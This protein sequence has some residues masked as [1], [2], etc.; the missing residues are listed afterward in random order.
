MSY[1]TLLSESKVDLPSNSTQE[2]AS[3]EAVSL[4]KLHS[5]AVS[6]CSFVKFVKIYGSKFIVSVFFF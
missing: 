2:I 1:V 5:E 4:W 3:D 6:L